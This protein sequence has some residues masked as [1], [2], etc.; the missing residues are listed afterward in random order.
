M[1]IEVSDVL[2]MAALMV[3]VSVF[4]FGYIEPRRRQ[5]LLSGVQY[6]VDDILVTGS[7]LVLLSLFLLWW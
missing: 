5:G 3:F 2:A 6:R 4:L 7:I 1:E